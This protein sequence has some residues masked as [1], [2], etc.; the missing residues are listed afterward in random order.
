MIK[1]E[2]IEKYKIYL[3]Y[4][5]KKLGTFFEEQAPYVFCKE[6]CSHCCEN[7]EFP[8]S[9]I[10]FAYLVLGTQTLPLET[11]Q[12]IEQNVIA[13]KEEKAKHP[14]SKPF[15]HA[16]PFLINKKCSLYEFRAIICRAHGL[17]FFGKNDNILVPACVHIGLNYAN[18]YDFETK[19]ISLEK[20]QKTGIKQEP[21]A[22][23]VRLGFLTNNEIT[24]ELGLN[25][26][27]IKPLLDWFE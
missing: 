27:E 18:V 2:D 21:L 12:L 1:I 13:L 6:G 11:Q 20:Y 10:E 16:C 14:S 15:C 3:A 26:G 19:K 23:N 9:E 8:F 17:A 24:K 7:G 25:F 22:H 4:L 5:S